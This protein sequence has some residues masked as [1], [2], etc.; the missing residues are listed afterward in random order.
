MADRNDFVRGYF[1]AVAA[2]SAGIL[3]KRK[4]WKS[5]TGCQA[6]RS[7]SPTMAEQIMWAVKGPNGQMRTVYGLHESED[8]AWRAFAEAVYTTK[9]DDWK[10]QL[11][12]KGYRCIRVKVVEVGGA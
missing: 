6:L 7:W 4:S 1:C 10:F 3:T 5:R 11:V 8:E 9:R 12:D 2:P